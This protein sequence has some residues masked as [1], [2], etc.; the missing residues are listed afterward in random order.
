M[1]WNLFS[2]LAA[3]GL[4]RAAALIQ[5]GY[6]IARQLARLA[7]FYPGAAP[8]SLEALRVRALAA[9]AAA[10]AHNRLPPEA[11]LRPFLAP[12]N[13]A[14]APRWRYTIELVYI[15]QRTGARRSEW[16]NVDRDRPGT[17]AEVEAEALALARYF[18]A[19]PRRRRNDPSPELP[20]DDDEITTRAVL[21]QRGA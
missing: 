19:A 8:Q 20:D 12:R 16:V 15:D 4:R 13:P 1:R 14:L 3:G 2:M 17:R 21:V 6:S 7:G 18:R 5:S 11:A 9:R 10:Q